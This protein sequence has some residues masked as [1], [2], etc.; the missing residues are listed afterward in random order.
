MWIYFYEFSD[1][2]H[3]HKTS[4]MRPIIGLIFSESIAFKQNNNIPY[5]SLNIIHPEQII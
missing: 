3:V 4:F 2:A 5:L 1:Y